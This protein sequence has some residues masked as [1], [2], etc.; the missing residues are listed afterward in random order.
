MSVT[1]AP[2]RTSKPAGVALLESG[3]PQDALPYLLDAQKKDPAN[4]EHYVNL[5][6]AYRNLGDWANAVVA[7]T[8]AIRLAPEQPAMW[9]NVAVLC[10][11]FGHFEDAAQV[12]DPLYEQV[13][14]HQQISLLYAHSKLRRGEWKEA[15]SAWEI[16]RFGKA[17]NPIPNL[18]V[19]KGEPLAGKKLLVL[20]E[21]GYGDSF[22]FQRYFRLLSEAGVRVY[23]YLWDNQIPVFEGHPHIAGFVR[24][25]EG[26]DPKDYDYQTPLLSLPRMFSQS[27]AEVPFNEFVPKGEPMLLLASKRQRIGLC[28]S[29]EENGVTRKVRSVPHQ[30]VE[31]LR[32]TGDCHAVFPSQET[33]EWV[34]RHSLKDWRD[35]VRLIRSMDVV[36]SVDTAVAHLAAMLGK[37]TFIVLPPSSDW[38]WLLG[39]DD[40]V[41]HPTARVFRT[42]PTETFE[43][44]LQRVAEALRGRV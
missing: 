11:D 10:E 2:I 1:T 33:P 15:W 19:W 20:C 32:G 34:T 23:F 14:M 13:P 35:T 6:I 37:E 42:A 44:T 22:L 26:A 39:R 40:T 9:Y 36:V 30:M 5:G 28:W 18:T 24:A 17:W 41:W 4:W 29:A 21:G 27:P 16:G 25:S 12:I 31:I 8:Q 7:Y 38:K 43:N 3:L